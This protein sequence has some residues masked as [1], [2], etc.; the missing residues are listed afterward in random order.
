MRELLVSILLVG[1]AAFTLIA[2]I[3]LLRAPDTHS[4]QQVSTKA[5]TFGSAGA[6]VG[7]FVFFGGG[8][9][10]LLV[11]GFL[12]LTVPVGTHVLAKAIYE[13]HHHG[14]ADPKWPGS[15]GS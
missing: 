12:L 7:S 2:G 10:E 1:G 4:R 8:F 6:L 3:G 9:Q 13:L 14:R 11:A 15:E 5:A